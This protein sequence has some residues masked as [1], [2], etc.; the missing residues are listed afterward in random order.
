M[1]RAA[2]RR[3]LALATVV[4]V[5]ATPAALLASSATAHHRHAAPAPRVAHAAA[6]PA[7]LGAFSD[8]VLARGGDAAVADAQAHDPALEADRAQLM[9]DGAQGRVWLIPTTDGQLCLGVEPDGYYD[10]LTPQAAAIGV[11][12]S[13]QPAASAAA[14]GIQLG[15]FHDAVGV[16]PDGVTGV[17]VT[18]VDGSTQKLALSGNVWRYSYPAQEPPGSASVSFT[19][20]GGPVSAPVF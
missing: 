1:L 5:M 9:A 16:V 19:T 8:G 11:A 2:R 13:C 18:A 20:S 15:V 4:V 12:Y 17:A 10:G 3:R 7:G 6:V 14:A